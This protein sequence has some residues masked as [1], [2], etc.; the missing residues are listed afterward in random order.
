MESRPWVEELREQL[1]RQGLPP[2]YIDRLVAELK[3]HYLDILEED[4]SMEATGT[5][6]SSDRLGQPAA[7]AEITATEYR[8][9]SFCRQYPI[10][11]FAVLPIPVQVVL[12]LVFY[13]TAIGVTH[14]VRFESVPTLAVLEVIMFGLLLAPPALAAIIFCRLARLS[15]QSW[16]WSMLSCGILA[17]LG[18]FIGIGGP[19]PFFG[20]RPAS[21]TQ[22]II[23]AIPLVFC[24]WNTWL[25]AKT[26]HSAQVVT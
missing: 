15:G 23:I 24:M 16:R 9:A 12:W 26:R 18:G 14:F 25:I 19:A 21:L 6:G 13:S 5:Q 8:R 4:R 1:A 22:W 17:A 3:D 7:L 10:L 2:S 20:G 11:T